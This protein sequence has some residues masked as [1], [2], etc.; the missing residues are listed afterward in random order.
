MLLACL[1]FYY[2]AIQPAEQALVMQRV[3]TEAPRPRAA[4]W[5][6]PGEGH[7]EQLRRFYGLF[8]PLAQLPDELGRLYAFARNAHLDLP[9]GDY[10]LEDDGGPLAEYRVTLPLRGS[11][12]EIRQFVG[13]V[14]RAMPV[15]SIDSLQFERASA[16]ASAVNAQVQLTLFF[17]TAEGS[18]AK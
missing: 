7:A 17:R 8:P 12:A 14:L 5:P 9:S 2:W 3:A 18:E 4:R 10:R 16:Q 6:A 15:A 11:Y 1:P 13:Q